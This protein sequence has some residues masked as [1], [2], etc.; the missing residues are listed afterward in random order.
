MADAPQ[1]DGWKK[2]MRTLVRVSKM[3]RTSVPFKIHKYWTTML[4]AAS[5]ALF[6]KSR[7]LRNCRILMLKSDK[8]QPSK[9]GSNLLPFEQGASALGS[10]SQDSHGTTQNSEL[11]VVQYGIVQGSHTLR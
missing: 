6:R 2:L 4:L 10:S 8:C 11:G 9:V 7:G 1:R 5:A 3:H